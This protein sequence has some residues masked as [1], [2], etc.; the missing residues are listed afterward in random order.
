MSRPPLFTDAPLEAAIARATA[1]EKLVLIDFTADWCEPCKNMDRT[2]WRDAAVEA[3]VAANAIAVQIDVD[4]DEAASARFN[5]KAMPTMVVLRGDAEIDRTTGGRPA[6]AL[7]RWL[8]GVRSGKTELELAESSLNPADCSA[9][10]H[11]A[12]LLMARGRFDD[13]LTHV[14]YLWLHA[15]EHEPAWTGVRHS[16]LAAVMAS[17]AEIHP[18]ARAR[19]TSL[20]D[21]LAGQLGDRT[22]FCDWTTLNRVLGDEAATLAWFDTVKASPP[23]E[24]QL[25]FDHTITTLLTEHERWTDLGRLFRNPVEQITPAHELLTEVER[26]SKDDADHEH[27]VEFFRTSFRTTAAEV[28]KALRA[29]GRDGEIAAV[30]AEAR[31]LDPSE[32]MSDALR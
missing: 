1:E 30:S 10:L 20:R 16:F 19:F 3:W 4:A 8:E 24:L 12:R 28:I 32:E 17:L 2:T 25:E 18:A 21:G 22:A 5:V 23:P 26:E 7:L 27:M 9:R 15:L 14:E 11:L 13:A 31:R 29:A 6:D